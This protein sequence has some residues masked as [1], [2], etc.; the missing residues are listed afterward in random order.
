MTYS[1][2]NRPLAPTGRSRGS[3]DGGAERSRSVMT[4]SPKNRPLARLG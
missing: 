4:L 1:P 2:K 3:A